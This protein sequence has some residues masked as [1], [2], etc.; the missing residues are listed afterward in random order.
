ML[1]GICRFNFKTRRS[2][3]PLVFTKCVDLPVGVKSP[4]I[5]H[6]RHDVRARTDAKIP[7]MD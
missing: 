4:V 6:I 3:V 7:K 5:L 2:D 1:P